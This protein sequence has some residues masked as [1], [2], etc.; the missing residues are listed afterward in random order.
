MMRREEHRR[1]DAPPPSPLS[2]STLCLRAS[3]A[4]FPW[5]G[6]APWRRGGFTLVELLVS[7]GIM[8]ALVAIVAGVY[9]GNV[10]DAKERVLRANLRAFRK[11]IQTFYNDHGRYPYDSFKG[12]AFLDSSS[13]ELTQGAVQADGV[14][15]RGKYLLEIPVDPTTGRAD[16]VLIEAKIDNDRDGKIDEDRYG[17]QDNEGQPTPGNDDDDNDGLV[18]EDPVDI[19]G[20]RSSNPLYS[21]L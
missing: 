12:V 4:H 11:A 13:S 1:G 10:D 14:R 3:V 7:L 21:D 15:L 9:S 16:W 18:D 17:D 6:L 8:L 5:R 20:V 2:S 19:R